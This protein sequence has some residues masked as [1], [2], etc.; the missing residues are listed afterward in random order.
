[1]TTTPA[2]AW[3]SEATPVK[4][5]R[6]HLN[7]SVQSSETAIAGLCPANGAVSSAA[8]HAERFPT[9]LA[10]S[11]SRS[12]RGTAQFLHKRLHALCR[13]GNWRAVAESFAAIPSS[14]ADL[15]R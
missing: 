8:A 3:E 12:C 15:P 13:V 10:A 14:L 5:Q 11:K 6:L 2:P 9:I 7:I 4:A 1:M